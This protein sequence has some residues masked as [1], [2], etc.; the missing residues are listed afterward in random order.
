MNVIL[1]YEDNH[2]LVGVANNYYNAVKLLIADDWISDTTEICIGENKNS[3]EWK[4]L[5]EVFGED[6]ADKMLEQWDIENFNDYWRDTFLL[7]LVKVFQG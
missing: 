5:K 7:E 3:Y 2:G 6:W 4:P 1:I